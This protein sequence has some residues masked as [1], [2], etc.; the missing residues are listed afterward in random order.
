MNDDDD[1]RRMSEAIVWDYR[2]PGPWIIFSAYWTICKWPL[3]V[4]AAFAVLLGFL[5]DS[6]VLCV[7]YTCALFVV[8]LV[9]VATLYAGVFLTS[10]LVR[11]KNGIS[12]HGITVCEEEY[13]FDDI[14]SLE[15]NVLEGR[16]VIRFQASGKLLRLIVPEDVRVES[17]HRIIDDAFRRHRHLAP[18]DEMDRQT[19]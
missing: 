10:M 9:V 13:A 6:I 1:D 2:V 16:L 12:M 4:G 19:S 8:F 5:T 17:V 15:S 14:Q 7:T 3:P 11:Y 18:E